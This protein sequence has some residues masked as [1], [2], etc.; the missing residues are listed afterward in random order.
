MIRKAF[1]MQINANSHEEYQKRHTP[2]WPELEQVLKQHGVHHYAIYLNPTRDLLFATVEIES[3]ARWEA[4]A[5]T[6]VCKRWW[7]YMCEVMPVN[8]DNS[9]V[10]ETLKEVFYLE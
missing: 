5:Q 3:E 2:I 4:I 8:A 6:D 7:K 9:H 1:M 10:S